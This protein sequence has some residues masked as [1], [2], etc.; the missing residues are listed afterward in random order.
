MKRYI[1]LV[2]AI[3]AVVVFASGCT[4]STSQTYNES[5]VSFDY[6]MGWTKLSA[7]QMSTEVEGAAPMV[8]A[9]ADEDS[10]SNNTY[11]TLVAVQKTNSTGTLDEGVSASKSALESEGAVV[12]S[13]SNLTVD[14]STAREFT[15]TMKI[16]SVDKKESIIIFEKNNY[17]YAI[18][19]SAKASDFDSQKENFDMII[20]SFKVT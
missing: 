15:Y 11:Q 14:G 9:V 8:A 2:L 20:K 19:L 7:S 18:T 12:V 4:T 3:L 16:G 10:I 6:P 13:E 5:G 1:F 17:I